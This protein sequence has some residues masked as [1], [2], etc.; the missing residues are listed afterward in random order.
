VA[1][2][3]PFPRWPRWPRRLHRWAAVLLAVVLLGALTPSGLAQATDPLTVAQAFRAAIAAQDPDAVLAVWAE[4]GVYL[5][6][7]HPADHAV[8]VRVGRAELQQRLPAVFAANQR[9]RLGPFRV[10]GDV[11]SYDWQTSPDPAAGRDLPP[12]T[13]TDELVVREG[14]IQSWTEHADPAAADRQRRAL[15]AVLAARAAQR[16]E[17]AQAT[18][19]AASGVLRRTPDTQDRRT[20]SPA[21]WGAGAVAILLGVGLAALARPRPTP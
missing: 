1:D 16:A 2:G 3:T 12:L 21:L 5:P 11:V 6:A 19:I 15:D 4:D 14:K 9:T 7:D 13:G 8:A 17:D 10:A 20:A 18:T